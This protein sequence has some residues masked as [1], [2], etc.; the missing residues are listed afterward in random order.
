MRIIGVVTTSR[1]DYGVYIPILRKIEADP[2]LDLHLIV[3]GM[4]LAPEFGLTEEAILEDGFTIDQRVEL[5]VPLDTPAA[6]SES[7]GRGIIG[8]AKAYESFQPDILLVLGDRFEMHAA[9]LAALPFK[10]PVGHV[11]GGEITEG[12]IDDA[13]RHSITKLSHLHFVSTQDY[14][15]RVEQLGEEPWRVTISGAP[16]ID[17]LTA[18]ELLSRRDLEAK[19]GFKLDQPPLLITYHPVTLEHEQTEWQVSQLLEALQEIDLPMVFTMPNADTNGRIIHRMIQE[20]V[21]LNPARWLVDNL[22][23]RNYYSLMALAAAMIG[24]SSSGILEAPSFGLPVVNIGTRQKGR[25]RTPNI[26]DVGYSK[27]EVSHG[28]QKAISNEFRESVADLPS[29]YGDGNAAER[30]ITVLKQTEL[31]DRLVT[32]R[33]VDWEPSPSLAGKK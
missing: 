1:A 18:F 27:A 31:G 6:I 7:M 30:I 25:L 8:F 2:D 26:V 21:N 4:H 12:A 19:F 17:N 29:P 14:A 13:L 10:I 16:S 22:G 28:I 3:G 11:H 32:K 15:R 33:F 24:N 9:A 23:T 5:L 20:F